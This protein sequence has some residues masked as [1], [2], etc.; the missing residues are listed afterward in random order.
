M[1]IEA[2]LRKLTSTNAVDCT[3]SC[4]NQR[5]NVSDLIRGFH[6]YAIHTLQYIPEP[7][8]HLAAP[9]AAN[10]AGVAVCDPP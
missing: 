3:V 5:T 6:A 8:G 10:L 9:C 1:R 4:V 7:K 2:K